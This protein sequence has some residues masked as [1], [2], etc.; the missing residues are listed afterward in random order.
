MFAIISQEN[1]SWKALLKS[2]YCKGLF[3]SVGKCLGYEKQYQWIIFDHDIA[4]ILSFEIN[5]CSIT[6]EELK[7]LLA[8]YICILTKNLK[9]ICPFIH[10]IR[11]G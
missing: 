7:G 11:P 8:L 6:Q 10:E 4:E 2:H 3:H 9:T 5:Y 1:N